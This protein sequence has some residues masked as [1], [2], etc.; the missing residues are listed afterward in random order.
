M[1]TLDDINQTIRDSQSMP[2]DA[3]I[4]P[5]MSLTNALAI[6]SLGKIEIAM[7]LEDRFGTR[8]TDKDVKAFDTPSAILA[9]AQ[10]AEKEMTNV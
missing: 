6:D 5:H 8:F 7:L 1:I 9:L 3:P 4:H 2:L 10:R